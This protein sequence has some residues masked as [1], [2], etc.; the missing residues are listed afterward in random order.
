MHFEFAETVRN[1]GLPGVTVEKGF[2]DGQSTGGYSFG[3]VRTDVVLHSRPDGTGPAIAIWDLKT[4]S[5]ILTQPRV[6]Q[7]RREVEGGAN[8]YVI[9]LHALNGTTMK[10]TLY[11]RPSCPTP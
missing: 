7:L 11:G 3:D 5:A 6:D 2:Q 8:A 4:G 1:L 9:E 10:S